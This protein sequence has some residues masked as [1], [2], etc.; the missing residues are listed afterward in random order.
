MN[1]LEAIRGGNPDRF[2]NQFEAVE[3]MADPYSKKNRGSLKPGGEIINSWG[4][5]IR[6]QENTPGPFPVHDD[7]HKVLKD[8]T[9][10]EEV[11]KFPSL[12]FPQEAWDECRAA[13][14]K[15]DRNEKFATALIAPGVF[16][17][18]HYLM[19]MEDCLLSFY[20]E[21]DALKGLINRI[22]EWELEYAR[23][24][25]ENLHPT[26]VLH[27]DDWGSQ[28]ST[29][30][31]PDM[32]AEFIF[33]SYKK[34]YGYYKEHG[35]EVVIHH[36]DSYAATIVPHMIDVGIDV[37]QGCIDTNDMPTLIK[38]Y[39]GQIAFMGAINNGIVDVPGWTDKLIAETVEK[40]CR[41][42][43]KLYFIPCCT[44]GG[45]SSNYPGVFDAVTREIDKMSEI[46]F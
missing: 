45:P 33:P 44:A 21:P 7:E 46:M 29:F 3:F 1:M 16:D 42:C 32:F 34:I 22:T 41:E 19:G 9:E 43:G 28:R 18:L 17:H 12:D 14:D 6:F 8:I 13:A 24:L 30:L 15:I 5:T 36:S 25:C 10:W 40:V 2:V 31:S 23:L 38:Q 11:V 37:W 4:V 26:A 20:T 39:G 27:H 35:V